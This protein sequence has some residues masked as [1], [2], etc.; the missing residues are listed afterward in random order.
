[1]IP[2]DIEHVIFRRPWIY[3]LDVIIFY[4]WNSCSFSFKGRKPNLLD[5][6]QHLV[7]RTRKKGEYKQKRK[8]MSPNEFVDDVK[9]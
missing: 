6:H 3:D 8:T 5:Y 1:V 9:E 2:M 4:R 7:I